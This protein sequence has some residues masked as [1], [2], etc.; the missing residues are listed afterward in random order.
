MYEINDGNL[1]NFKNELCELNDADFIALMLG[2]ETYDSTLTE[3]ERRLEDSSFKEKYQQAIEEKY[4]TSAV[5][6]SIDYIPLI[7]FILLLMCGVYL[8]QN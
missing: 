8:L 2:G 1:E 4:N 6:R 7:V 5:K 3:L